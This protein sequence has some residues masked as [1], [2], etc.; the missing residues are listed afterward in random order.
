MKIHEL[1]SESGRWCRGSAARDAA[2]VPIG[3][4]DPR[5]TCWC[6]QGAATVCYP[7]ADV[8]GV[9]ERMRAASG[10]EILARWNDADQRTFDQVR[11]LVVGLDV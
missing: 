2:G 5:A 9:C 7:D 8:P 3:P 10:A 11:S 1:L 6:L 4:H